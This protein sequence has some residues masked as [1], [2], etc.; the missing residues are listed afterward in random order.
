MPAGSL[1]LSSSSFRLIR[2]RHRRP[3]R[4]S[5]RHRLAVFVVAVFVVFVVTALFVLLVVVIPGLTGPF[6][7]LPARPT[8]SI[9]PLS[10]CSS[11]AECLVFLHRFARRHHVTNPAELASSFQTIPPPLLLQTEGVLSH[12]SCAPTSVPTVTHSRLAA[13]PSHH[14]APVCRIPL[15]RIMPGGSLGRPSLHGRHAAAG[16]DS[17]DDDNDDEWVSA[18]PAR[19]PLW[20]P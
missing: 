18:V 3:V 11:S 9:F 6:L 15:Q 12:V 16:R 19:A 2:R 8:R 14:L 5:F 1:F 10:V 20:L 13:L 17:D 4:L 7:L